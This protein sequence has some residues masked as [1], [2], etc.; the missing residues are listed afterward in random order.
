MSELF[1]LIR[2][3][4]KVELHLHL[5]GALEPEMAFALA[6]RNGVALPY[7][8]A[9]ELAAAFEFDGL[10]EFLDVYYAAC[11]ALQTERDFY[12]LTRAYLERAAADNVVHAEVFF[13]PQTH[14][15]RGVSFD[16]IVG[17]ITRALADGQSELGVT[18]ALI[19]CF[20]RHLSE[21]QALA[22]LE[23]A[24]AHRSEITGVGLDSGERGNPP[25]K[26]ARAFARAR[27]MGFRAVAHAGEEAGPDYIIEALDI[28]GVERIDHGV[29]CE[30]DDA[31]VARLARDAI[32]LTVCPLSNVRLRVFDTMA[33]HN[34]GRLLDRGLCVTVN[35]D[36]PA[37]FGGYIG[38]NFDAVTAALEL[39]REALLTL[40]KNAA[41]A[42]FVSPPRRAEILAAIDAAAASS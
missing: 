1:E 29:R 14:T 13:D 10:E 36:D 5:E 8:S 17:G 16:A 39:D 31:L 6:E 12:D 41:E 19:M 18:S 34:L 9:A 25:R 2:R 35:S 23:Q 33:A 26:Y 38:E 24:A 27:E 7:A 30:E 28:L 20:L 42:A 15:A 21:D 3:L 40:A 32:P 22:T 4:P 11:A 37:Y